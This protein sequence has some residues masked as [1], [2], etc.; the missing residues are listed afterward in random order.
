MLRL[1]TSAR[2]IIN[3]AHFVQNEANETRRSFLSQNLR[4]KRDQFESLFV[5]ERHDAML[6]RGERRFTRKA[7]MGAL[8][9]KVRQFCRVGSVR[10]V[11]YQRE[12]YNH[13]H[14]TFNHDG[15][16]FMA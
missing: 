9:I 5:A 2:Q 4:I 6:N 1:R 13:H 15:C 14:A 10:V 8:M 11:G 7:L 3:F 12:L 16:V